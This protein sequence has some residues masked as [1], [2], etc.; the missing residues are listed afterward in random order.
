V[1]SWNGVKKR[2]GVLSPE[3]KDFKE[4][5]LKAIKRR[6]RA[7]LR[8]QVAETLADDADVDDIETMFA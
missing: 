7:Y 5:R 8:K 3:Q 2:R 4:R 1:T 6:H